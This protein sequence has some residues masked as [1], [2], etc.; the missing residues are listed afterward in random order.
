M[1]NLPQEIFNQIEAQGRMKY[2]LM[3]TL[4]QAPQNVVPKI[5]DR[6]VKK[7]TKLI[8]D[9]VIQKPGWI[10]EHPETIALAVWE[11]LPLY[12]EREAMQSYI[13]QVQ[14]VDLYHALPEILS[15]DEAAHLAGLE[16]PYLTQKDKTAISYILRVL[17]K[18]LM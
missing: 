14:S 12:L 7:L 6:E 2:P 4:F 3:R 10:D 15:E 9:A 18:E 13:R 16:R 8:E 1:L 11:V 5:E 17:S